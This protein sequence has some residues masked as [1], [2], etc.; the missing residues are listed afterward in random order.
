M[1]A[2]LCDMLSQRSTM[3]KLRRCGR[4]MWR[5]RTHATDAMPA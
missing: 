4:R 1:R 5:V 3:Q 2:N